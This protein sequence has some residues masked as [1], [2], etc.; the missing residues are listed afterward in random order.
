[1]ARSVAEL[2]AQAERWLPDRFQAAREV[3]AAVA[4]VLQLGE[5][6]GDDLSS[7]GTFGGAS[8]I[9]LDLHARTHG[10]FRATA[11]ADGVLR[12]RLRNV[13]E[14]LTRQAILDAVD[15]ILAEVTSETATMVEWFEPDGAFYADD[16]YL[17]TTR[18][19]GE[20]NTFYLF[21]PLL[22]DTGWGDLYVDVSYLDDEY[23]GGGTTDD[24]YAA[25]IS[26]VE[27]LRAAGIRWLLIME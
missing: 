3:T 10:L 9:W 23:L 22:G 25:I 26:E 11:E 2:L 18:L 7:A 16:G 17:D 27:R 19:L 13:E 21:V 8:G 6:A 14:R 24:V 15:A 12:A 5:T 1:M 4:A 20:W